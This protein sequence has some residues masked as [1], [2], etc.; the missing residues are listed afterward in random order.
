MPAGLKPEELAEDY[1]RQL[2]TTRSGRRWPSSIEGANRSWRTECN[3]VHTCCAQLDP[4]SGRPRV[5]LGKEE[6]SLSLSLLG[7]H[8]SPRATN[9]FWPSTSAA[10]GLHFGAPP[11][12]MDNS[13][14]SA[15]SKPRRELLE[16]HF[17]LQLFAR[18]TF[19]TCRHLDP[20]SRAKVFQRLEAP[21]A[22]TNSSQ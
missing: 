11:P 2:S 19:I 1:E 10:G 15:A 20:S 22:H 13:N 9:Y 3:C 14:Q 5:C 18:L 7:A 12:L 21:R 16:P 4:T 6:I 8:F 17:F